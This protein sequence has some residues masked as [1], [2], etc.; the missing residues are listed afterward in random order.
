[1]RNKLRAALEALAGQLAAGP[2]DER[3]EA[4]C[5]SQM[6]AAVEAVA[7]ELAQGDAGRARQRRSEAVRLLVK[8]G[9]AGMLEDARQSA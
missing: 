9:A 4:A 3:L 2:M 8:R 5:D 1:M 7:L 6:R